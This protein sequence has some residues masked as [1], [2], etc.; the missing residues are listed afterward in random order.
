MSSVIALVG[1]VGLGLLVAIS[2]RALLSGAARVWLLSLQPPP[3]AI[4]DT[5]LGPIWATLQASCG[6]AGWLAWRRTGAGPALRLWGWQLAAGAARAAAFLGIHNIALAVG[7]G[8]VV[9]GLLLAVIH[10]FGALHRGAAWLMVPSLLWTCYV[11]YL[12][13]GFVLLNPG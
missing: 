9:F 11:L 3:G 8:L 1:F 12:D 5:A 10:R 13:A 4:P 6:A 7:L 2:E